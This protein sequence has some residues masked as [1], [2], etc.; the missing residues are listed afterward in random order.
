[1]NLKH[2]RLISL[3]IVMLILAIPVFAQD[4]TPDAVPTAVVI[5]VEQLPDETP[6]ILS[7]TI[8]ELMAIVLGIVG[9]AVAGGK[10]LWDA[11]QNPGGASVD[12][13]LTER[14][15]V[16]QADRQ[17]MDSIERGY[18]LS[19]AGLKTALDATV[20]VLQTIAPLTPLKVDDAAL[21]LLRDVQTPGAK[22]V[23]TTTTSGGY[24]ETATS[25]MP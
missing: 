7:L 13:R 25:P 16:A 1:M 5:P 6:A 11:N 21:D 4:A 23:T 15:G 24:V 8:G 22:T 19:N 12:Q 10:I 2:L 14:V 17:W 20:S 18:A 3:F 9:L